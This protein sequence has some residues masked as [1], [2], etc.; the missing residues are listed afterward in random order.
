[1]TTTYTPGALTKLSIDGTA[2]AAISEDFGERDT[3]LERNGLRGTRTHFNTDVRIGPKHVAGQITLEP[4]LAELLALAKLAI[5]NSNSNESISS[6]SVVVDRNT[7][8]KTYAGCKINRLRVEGKQGGLLRAVADI[9]GQTETANGNVSTP[10]DSAPAIFSDIVLTLESNARETESFALEINNHIDG[11]R[12]LNSQTLPE[13][14]ELD[15][16]V[17]LKTTHPYNTATAAAL[18]QQAVA[19]AAGSLAMNDGTNT[20]TFSFGFLQTPY[21]TPS[22]PGKQEVL[23][24]LDMT[25]RGAT[26]GSDVS[27][28]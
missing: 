24:N 6:F 5:G 3:H 9:I 21:K 19:G 27:V 13:V 7:E 20:C 26:A 22:V 25:S 4:S 16:T 11:D 2:M 14:V 15:R 1:M 28:A 12:F 23:I 10:A 8:S 17:T 18:L